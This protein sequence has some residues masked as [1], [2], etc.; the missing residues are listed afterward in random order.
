MLAAICCISGP[1]VAWVHLCRKQSIS[2]CLKVSLL[3]PLQTSAVWMPLYV[4]HFMIPS[5]TDQSRG[6]QGLLSASCLWAITCQIL[7]RLSLRL[8][9]GKV[10]EA[11]VFACF[12]MQCCVPMRF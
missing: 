4:Q 9:V 8:A 10:P 6:G 3:I 7:H 1:S 12:S 11:D 2:V 5:H